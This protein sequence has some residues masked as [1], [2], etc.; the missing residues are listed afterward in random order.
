MAIFAT[1]LSSSYNT[2]ILLSVY[3]T[4]FSLNKT[5][6]NF[7]SSVFVKF[8]LLNWTLATNSHFQTFLYLLPNAENLWC[9]KLWQLTLIKHKSL[10]ET[11]KVCKDKRTGRLNIFGKCTIHFCYQV[12]SSRKGGCFQ[13]FGV[14]PGFWSFSQGFEVLPEVWSAPRILELLPGFC[15]KMWKFIRIL[16]KVF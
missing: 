15:S 4:F 11:S 1:T 12:D 13:G 10:F 8:F 7:A 16:W 9:F 6:S 2:Y 3:L 14:L 5:L